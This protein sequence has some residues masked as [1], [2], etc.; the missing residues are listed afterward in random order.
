MH[1]QLSLFG[2]I[3]DAEIKICLHTMVALSGMSPL[4]TREH[5][6]MWKPRNQFKPVLAAGEVNQIEQYRIMTST[7]VNDVKP[8]HSYTHSAES[9]ANREWKLTISEIPEAGK[10]KTTSQ[11][12][13]ES[14]V[15]YSDLGFFSS[16]KCADSRLLKEM[17]LSS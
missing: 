6:I 13:F 2:S 3:G 11:S 12:I 5:C 4:R 10:Q 7:E 15:S 14:K 1:Q 9:I 8:F 17:R 16:K